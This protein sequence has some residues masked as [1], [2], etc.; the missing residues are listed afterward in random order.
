MEEA[1]AES[2]PAFAAQVLGPHFE[3]LARTWTER[4][5]SIET[6]GGR[7]SHVGFAQVN[8]A[9]ARS[10]VDLDVVAVGGNLHA[11]RPRILAIGE[12]KGG[13]AARTVD[14]LRKLER[15]RTILGEQ[16]NTAKTRLLL[17]SRSGFEPALQEAARRR[18]DLELIDLERLYGGS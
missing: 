13:S 3:Q 17:F 7:A 9:E 16:A 8:D 1:W 11:D 18:A 10:R 14:D 15:G 2:Q 5:A 12:A 6:L 4:F